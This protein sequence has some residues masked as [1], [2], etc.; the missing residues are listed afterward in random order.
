MAGLAEGM[1]SGGAELQEFGV[2]H[3]EDDGVVG[4]GVRL[5]CERRDLV[6]VFGLGDV[7]PRVVGGY[8][9]THLTL[10]CGILGLAGLTVI[11][12]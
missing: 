5:G 11:F 6:F 3:G 2:C 7:D 9:L 4:I 12:C 1:D 8:P 10:A